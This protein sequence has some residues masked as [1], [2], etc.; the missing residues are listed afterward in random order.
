MGM[1]NDRHA[2]Q[3]GDS[4][5]RDPKT[6]G[7]PKTGFSSA[8]KGEVKTGGPGEAVPGKGKGWGK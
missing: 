6:S 4:L 7:T 8:P 2:P 1:S 5:S 3:N